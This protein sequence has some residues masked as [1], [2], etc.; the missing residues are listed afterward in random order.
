MNTHTDHMKTHRGNVY[1]AEC[2]CR[3]LLDVVANK[4][5]ALVIDALGNG[6]LRFNALQRTLDG[7]TPKVLTATLRRLESFELVDRV[8][9]AEVPVRVEY[10]LTEAGRSSLGPVAALRTWA[11]SQYDLASDHSARAVHPSE[12]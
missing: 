3:S 4:W 2:P 1:S 6:P 11:E 7:V 12:E 8:V 5:S 10:S 9:Y